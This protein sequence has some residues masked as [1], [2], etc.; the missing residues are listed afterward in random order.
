MVSYFSIRKVKY[1]EVY[2]D[3]FRVDS[4][5]HN[6]EVDKCAKLEEICLFKDAKFGDRFVTRDGHEAILYDKTYIKHMGVVEYDLMVFIGEFD[7][8]NWEVQQVCVRENGM[9][10][11]CEY[12]WD[13]VYKY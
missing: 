6:D 2:M 3:L 11:D 10:S 1:N 8:D 9:C 5:R 7:P 13:I 12:K 4:D